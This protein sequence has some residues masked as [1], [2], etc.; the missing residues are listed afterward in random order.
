MRLARCE[1]CGA[2]P[3]QPCRSPSNRWTPLHSSR[4]A[5]AAKLA[6][7]NGHEPRS[8]ATLDEVARIQRGELCAQ[9]RAVRGDAT[10]LDA[11]RVRVVSACLMR[12]TT[13]RGEPIAR[14]VL[15]RWQSPAELA[16]APRSS[17]AAAVASLCL[18]E[19]R[20]SAIIIAS[21]VAA[22][23]RVELDDEPAYS[24]DAVDVIVHGLLHVVP[25]DR[26]LRATRERLLRQRWV[27]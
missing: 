10:H 8:R 26:A 18:A 15:A 17:L 20:A 25:R 14:E 9:E 13:A 4:L 2:P 16:L 24:R 12:V 19:R 5:R 6:P 11:W 23:E 27:A 3:L 22:F 1:W 7:T 21:A